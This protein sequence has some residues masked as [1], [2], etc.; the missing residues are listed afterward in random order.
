MLRLFAWDDIRSI[1]TEQWW[2]NEKNWEKMS[3]V[4]EKHEKYASEIS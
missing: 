4:S 1:G 3:K 2:E